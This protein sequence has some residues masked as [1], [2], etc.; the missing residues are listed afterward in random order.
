MAP[1][2]VLRLATVAVGV[3]G[4]RAL[5]CFSRA[6]PATA[7]RS[8]HAIPA[9]ARIARFPI[10]ADRRFDLEPVATAVA[11][12]AAQ[13]STVPVVRLELLEA[14]RAVVLAMAHAQLFTVLAP[15]I[16]RARSRR[17]PVARGNTGG[18]RRA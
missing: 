4:N 17:G 10:A 11:L 18:A 3:A 7:D 14:E 1:R 13:T 2:R 8:L 15:V 16:G 5:D 12:V 6:F 9:A